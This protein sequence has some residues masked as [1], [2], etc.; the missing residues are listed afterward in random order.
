[1]GWFCAAMANE[2]CCFSRQF[3]LA[4]KILPTPLGVAS[5][6]CAG[7]TSRASTLGDCNLCSLLIVET[8]G[9]GFL[10]MIFFFCLHGVYR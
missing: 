3:L 5:S 6:I 9:P 8:I 7:V 1:M 2:L 4:R 10:Q